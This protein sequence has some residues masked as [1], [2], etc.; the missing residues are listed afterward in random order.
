M[1]IID[2]TCHKVNFPLEAPILWNAGICRSWTRIIVRMKTDEGLEGIGECPGGDATLLHLHA[3]KEYFIGEDPFDREKIL[4]YFTYVQ[5]KHGGGGQAAINALETCCFDLM[6]KAT[7][8]PVCQ[9]LGGKVRDKVPTIAYTYYRSHGEDGRGGERT[10]AEVVGHVRDLVDRH[11]F[12]TIKLKGGVYPPEEE[13]ETIAALRDAFPNHK[14][15]F[16]PNG[17][18][19]VETGIRI[20]KKFE[21]LALEYYEDPVWGLEGMSRVARKV[22]LP[23]ATNMCVTNLDEIAPGVRLGSIAVLLL[24]PH[25]W[26]GVGATMKAAA[27]CQIFQLGIGFHS[28]GEAGIST[29]I[30]LHIAAALPVLPY[31]IDSHYHHQLQDVITR[32]HEYIDGCFAVPDGPGLGVEIDEDQLSRLEEINRKEGNFDISLEE[33]TVRPQNFIGMW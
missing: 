31:A 27:A 26:G 17:L 33:R 23:L 11:G 2:V 18:W 4:R 13:F 16:D 6:G 30:H 10:P 5:I 25:V 19:S 9:L 14:L 15:R 1:R 22:D 12:E 7:G 28:G 24:D 21:G 32:P 3:L 20:G 8:R 29:A